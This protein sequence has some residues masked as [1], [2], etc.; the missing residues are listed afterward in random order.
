MFPESHGNRIAEILDLLDSLKEASPPCEDPESAG[1]AHARIRDVLEGLT[2]FKELADA[3][4]D[5][6]YLSDASSTL[7]YA[8]RA[9]CRQLGY[10]S[11]EM[12]ALKTAAISPRIGMDRYA[13]LFAQAQ[14][15]AL[16]PFE[17]M[18]RRK[19]GAEFPAEVTLTGIASGGRALLLTDM[20]DISRR[21]EAESRLCE[22]EKRLGKLF[23]LRP[24]PCSP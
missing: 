3:S 17:T 21:K 12:V 4:N 23:M 6:L 14:K 15:E 9:C 24:R 10:A 19:D 20:R 7:L 22:S 1:A 16:A 18:Q 2:I 8:N 13:Q 5:G 11:E